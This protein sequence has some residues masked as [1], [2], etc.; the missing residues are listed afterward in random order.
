MNWTNSNNCT[1]LQPKRLLV[2]QN[3]FFFTRS[4]AIPFSPRMK[5]K[6]EHESLKFK[7]ILRYILKWK[8]TYLIPH[9][10]FQS[11]FWMIRITT[12]SVNLF[13]ILQ[14]NFQCIVWKLWFF[15]WF[16]KFLSTI[17]NKNLEWS[18][19]SKFKTF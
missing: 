2:L 7:Y 12:Q 10:L 16:S 6:S 3:R 1:I 8:Q 19:N 11:Q 4:S 18:Q 17:N 14:S 13:W 9:S 5:S 15:W